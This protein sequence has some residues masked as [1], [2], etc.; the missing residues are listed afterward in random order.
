VGKLTEIKKLLKILRENGVEE[1][2]SDNLHVK[3]SERAFLAKPI[4]NNSEFE[5]KLNQQQETDDEILFH[6]GV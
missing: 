2:K 1:Y 5:P 3:L 6:S 4:I